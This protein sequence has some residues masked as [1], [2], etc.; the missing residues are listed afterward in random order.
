VLSGSK[1]VGYAGA[2]TMLVLVAPAMV[3]A[4]LGAGAA[5]LFR[6]SG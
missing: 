3:A 2:A 1:P 6:R 5:W 4:Y